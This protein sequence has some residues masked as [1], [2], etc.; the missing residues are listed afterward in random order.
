M[1]K[2][3]GTFGRLVIGDKE[4]ERQQKIV[5][6]KAHRF[7]PL[8]IGGNKPE[9]KKKA[10]AAAVEQNLIEAKLMEAGI[11]P[12]KLAEQLQAVPQL[13]KEI[14]DQILGKAKYVPPA[15]LAGEDEDEP[16]LEIDPAALSGQAPAE[17]TA[18]VA[19]DQDGNGYS[20]IG[21]LLKALN[22]N[23]VSAEDALALELSRDGGPRK[24]GLQ[25]IN[26]KEQQRKGGPRAEVL[27]QLDRAL[28]K[29]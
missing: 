14:V 3:P 27:E 24:G 15:V 29:L 19:P 21:E 8:V 12:V 16:E 28:A 20:S 1:P 7:G 5:A 4:F 25:A 9:E 13:S 23:E 18:P 2:K 11:D 26:A 10:D 17:Q 6:V 22:A